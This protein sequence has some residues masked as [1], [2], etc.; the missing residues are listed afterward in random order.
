MVNPKRAGEKELDF[1]DPDNDKC[2][3]LASTNHHGAPSLLQSCNPTKPLPVSKSCSGCLTV[4]LHLSHSFPHF[5]SQTLYQISQSSTPPRRHAG[6]EGA[7]SS[8]CQVFATTVFRLCRHIHRT[9]KCCLASLTNDPTRIAVGLGLQIFL[10]CLVSGCC[11]VL[12]VRI[13]ILVLLSA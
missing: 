10:G 5:L 3:A 9:R 1:C 12:Y 11:G 6:G 2:G 4:S 8:S 13:S 7:H